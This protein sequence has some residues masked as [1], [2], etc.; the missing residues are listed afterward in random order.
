LHV[1][2][3][4]TITLP[5]GQKTSRLVAPFSFLANYRQI[6]TFKKNPGYQFKGKKDGAI[7]LKSPVSDWKLFFLGRVWR[8][9]CLLAAVLRVR[10]KNVADLAKSV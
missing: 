8:Q 6:S 9:L 4:R 1:S 10:S 2:K 7:H 3:L 5:P